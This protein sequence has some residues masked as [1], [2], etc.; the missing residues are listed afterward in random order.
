MIRGSGTYRKSRLLLRS[1]A[2]PGPC[3]IF[4]CLSPCRQ[5]TL[6]LVRNVDGRD[7]CRIAPT[8]AGTGGRCSVPGEEHVHPKASASRSECYSSRN[9]TRRAFIVRTMASAKDERGGRFQRTHLLSGMGSSL[10]ASEDIGAG[11]SDLTPIP[12]P[13]V[14]AGYTAVVGSACP[15]VVEADSDCEDRSSD[16]GYVGD[17]RWSFSVKNDDVIL[18]S[19]HLSQIVPHRNKNITVF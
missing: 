1:L 2:R 4:V 14:D 18:H 10:N 6:F 5:R 13:V 9:H 12:S 16:V 7:L 11:V 8:C 15:C 17:T 3:R 19:H